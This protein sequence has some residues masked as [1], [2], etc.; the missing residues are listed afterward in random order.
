MSAKNVVDAY[1]KAWEAKDFGT[2]RTY[3]ADRLDFVGPIDVFDNADDYIEAIKGLSQI[4]T[5]TETKREFV[6]GHDVAVF[7]DLQTVVA[8]AEP[9]AEWYRVEGDKISMIR[10]LFDPRPFAPPAA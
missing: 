6:D 8:A 5:G 1:R 7:Y 2:A 9:I 3:L 4:V 10:V